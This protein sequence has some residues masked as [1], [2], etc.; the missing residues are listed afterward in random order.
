MNFPENVVFSIG[1]NEHIC[2]L[3]DNKL[4][5][6]CETFDQL[7][8]QLHDKDCVN[9]AFALFGRK[10]KKM[11]CT[12]SENNMRL[13]TTLKSNVAVKLKHIECFIS[14]SILEQ[15]LIIAEKVSEEIAQSEVLKNLV[16]AHAEIIPGFAC[17]ME[18]CASNAWDRYRNADEVDLLN[19][20]WFGSTV[21]ESLAE[22]GLEARDYKS[23]NVG[24]RRPGTVHGLCL[25]DTSMIVPFDL[26]DAAACTYPAV[27]CWTFGVDSSLVGLAATAWAWIADACVMAGFNSQA[28]SHEFV[29]GKTPYG[30]IHAY[31]HPLKLA[32]MREWLGSEETAQL[33]WVSAALKSALVAYSAVFKQDAQPVTKAEAIFD[34]G[35]FY[36]EVRA[37]FASI[38]THM[39]T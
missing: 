37:I 33:P 26:A 25:I 20:M 10:R 29:F 5:Y 23:S 6:N 35:R 13:F 22:R 4:K 28:A 11:K 31:S 32:E 34:A 27:S 9:T 18:R 12:L 2:V 16:V 3:E 19:Y 36:R 1:T 14:P 21:L 8:D 15:D 39:L 17:V 24:V 30:S 38:P 7:V